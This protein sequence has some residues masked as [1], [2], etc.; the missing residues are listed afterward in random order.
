[1]YFHVD[2]VYQAKNKAKAII[3]KVGG[4]T[5]L[6]L[7]SEVTRL[8]EQRL[9]KQFMNGFL[10]RRF[11]MAKRELERSD[12]VGHS[13]KQIW[14]TPWEKTEFE[15]DGF[16]EQLLVQSM[17]IELDSGI[18]FE[19]QANCT[20]EELPILAVN[21]DPNWTIADRPQIARCI[22]SGLYIIEVLINDFTPTFL[23]LMNDKTLLMRDSNEPGIFRPTFSILGEYYEPEDFVTYWGHKPL[24]TILP[25]DNNHGRKIDVGRT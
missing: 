19:I 22:E 12:I 2:G 15:L 3:T 17:F 8:P 18:I 20:M 21:K 1:M 23:L 6:G 11:S 24:T 14:F 5:G 10:N 25:I 13:I 9:P 16:L 4:W 7:V